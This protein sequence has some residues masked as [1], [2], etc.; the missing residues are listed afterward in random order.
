MIT[1]GR[2][3]EVKDLH[4]VW[5]NEAKDFTKWL[6]EDEN[7]DIL[8]DAIGINISV[9]EVESAVG[10]F[11]ADILASEVGTGR[12]IIIENQLEKT[13]H[14]H[15]GKIITYASGKDAEIIIWLVKHAREEHKAAVA[16]LN[17][18]TYDKIGVF[19]CEIKLC[20]IGDS[21]PAVKFEVIEKPNNWIKEARRISEGMNDT[22]HKRYEYWLKF[23]EYAYSKPE[24]ASEFEHIIPCAK[25]YLIF[26]IRHSSAHISVNMVQKRNVL[27]AELFIQDDKDLFRHLEANKKDIEAK[28]GL[29]FSWNELPGKKASRIIKSIP[30]SFSDQTQ[31]EK[32]FE[33]LVNVVLKIKASFSPYIQ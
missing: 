1:L 14:D 5:Q 12:K 24:F 23:L 10:D 33:C 4:T 20:K 11:H 7:I 21:D 17:A 6:A 22:E 9:D 28:S 18:N 19:L 26:S 32:Q 25:H 3:E 13:D 8:S 15:L 31:W 2:L 16:W 29:E 30:A 27:E